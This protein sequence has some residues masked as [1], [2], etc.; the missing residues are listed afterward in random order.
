MLQNPVNV[1][2][3]NEDRITEFQ[4][5]NRRVAK[6]A[7]EMCDMKN[8]CSDQ[9]PSLYQRKGRSIQENVFPSEWSTV[10]SAISR[11]DLADGRQQK[12]FSVGLNSAYGF[13]TYEF[14]IN[15]QVIPECKTFLRKY[16]KDLS[17][18][19]RLVAINSKVCF[20]PDKIY[21]DTKSQTFGNIDAELDI[22]GAS[23]SPAIEGYGT[24]GGPLNPFYVGDEPNNDFKS[25]DVVE[26]RGAF[27]GQRT[28]GLEQKHCYVYFGKDT[29]AE[30]LAL[31]QSLDWHIYDPIFPLVENV[32][33][34]YKEKSSSAKPGPYGKTGY[35]LTVNFAN[36]TFSDLLL[37]AGEDYYFWSAMSATMKRESADMDLVI[38]WNNRL[39]GCS[40]EDN[41][42]Y[43][44]KLG[45]PTNWQYYQQ[46][47]MDSYYAEQGSDGDFTG[48]GK[49]SNHLLFFKEDCIIKVYGT[50]PSSYQIVTTNCYGVEKGSEKS[51]CV[52]NDMVFY[53]SRLGI[54]AYQGELPDCISRK[55]GDLKFD[56]VVA[57]TDGYKYYAT[58]HDVKAD[59]YYMLVCDTEN[60]LWHKE[61]CQRVNMYLW[62]E[63]KLMMLSH[64]PFLHY[65][66]NAFMVIN[67]DDSTEE[68]K[69]FA[70]FG[71]FDEYIENKKITNRI[72][73]RF[74]PE[75]DS[76]LKVYIMMD[77]SG[78]W[79]LVDTIVDQ[80]ELV[81]H[82][83]YL[84]RRCNRFSIKLEGEGRCRIDSI[85]RQ[86][87]E[88]TGGGL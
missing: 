20:F 5:W 59:E 27:R 11:Q 6:E 62:H 50:A 37:A 85:R 31:D 83:V 88:G 63:G 2:P 65:S 73:M 4:G 42:I 80:N 51:V 43:A 64:V 82:S 38:E 69:W 12:I 17:A 52:V 47:N 79:E 33:C 76:I 22:S 29:D 30:F 3:Y 61:E 13:P 49:Y 24:L 32:S 84:P 39:W 23:I 54:M 44:C 58:I 10:T 75:E 19:T 68:I 53:K 60:A 45:D 81:A 72:D 71:P 48:V 21:Y 14:A 78:E 9:Y 77:E 57:G 41:R 87:R 55:L 25:G 7:G 16:N 1:I 26:I 36:G 28:E 18:D 46:T 40:N 66:P 56:N 74:H 8:L 70:E 15:D 35:F 86:F 67:D 34:V